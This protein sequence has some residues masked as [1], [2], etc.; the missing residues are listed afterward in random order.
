MEVTL[1]VGRSAKIETFKI[2][3]F[4]CQ[5]KAPKI[6]E[7]AYFLNLAEQFWRYLNF[8]PPKMFF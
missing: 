1:Y 2:N 4:L 6:S 8:I 3:R 7:W 5:L